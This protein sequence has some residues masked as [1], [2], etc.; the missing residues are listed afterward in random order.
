MN[1]E[2]KIMFL[3]SVLWFPKG[4]VHTNINRS[5]SLETGSQTSHHKV[6]LLSVI[7]H[8]LPLQML[9]SQ[10]SS[11][12][13]CS[14]FKLFLSSQYWTGWASSG[15]SGNFKTTA[16][17]VAAPLSW[18]CHF[19]HRVV[20]HNA[21]LSCITSVAAISRHD[22]NKSTLVYTPTEMKTINGRFN[23]KNKKQK[24]PWKILIQVL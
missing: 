9:F 16:A 4:P 20:A 19:L 13:C 2:D 17:Q 11:C 21:E 5:P 18:V 1:E 3:F 15:C 7:S 8:V 24:K 23:L 22:W 6:Y 14:N 10:S 12:C